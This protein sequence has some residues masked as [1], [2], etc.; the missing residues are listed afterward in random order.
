MTAA[1]CLVV[2][3]LVGAVCGAA[4]VFLMFWSDVLRQ[5]ESLNRLRDQLDDWKNEQMENQR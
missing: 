4:V 3:W 1:A 5:R 2:G